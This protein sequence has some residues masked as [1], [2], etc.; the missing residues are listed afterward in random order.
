M[1]K[2]NGDII[3]WNGIPF[4]PLYNFNSYYNA[5]LV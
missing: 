2:Y 3:C 4:I 5:K 1:L